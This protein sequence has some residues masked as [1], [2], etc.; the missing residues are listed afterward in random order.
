MKKWPLFYI[1][2][3]C[4]IFKVWSIKKILIEI[5]GIFKLSPLLNPKDSF[6]LKAITKGRIFYQSSIPTARSPRLWT[7]PLTFRLFRRRLEATRQVRHVRCV[8]RPPRLEQTDLPNQRG[9]YYYF[10]F[11]GH[12]RPLFLYFRLYNIFFNTAVSK[13]IADWIQTAN[14]WCRKRPFYQLS[15]NHFHFIVPKH[16][17]KIELAFLSAAKA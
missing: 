15:H 3:D 7:S 2:Y 8:S 11:Y 6:G 5:S 10:C 16:V 4:S 14:L 17:G 9:H 13:K 1:K 12:S